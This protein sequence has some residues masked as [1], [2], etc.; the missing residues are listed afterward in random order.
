MSL[1]NAISMLDDIKGSYCNKTPFYLK[2]IDEL[3]GTIDTIKKFS[4]DKDVGSA[5]F[6]ATIGIPTVIPKYEYMIYMDI[7][8]RPPLGQFNQDVLAKIRSDYAK[9]FV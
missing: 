1:R 7:Y 6:S 4:K 8:G 5:L 3:I 2:I 9:Y